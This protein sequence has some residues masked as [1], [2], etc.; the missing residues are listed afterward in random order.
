PCLSCRG[1]G[2]SE[3]ILTARCRRQSSHRRHPR[4]LPGVRGAQAETLADGEDQ[5]VARRKMSGNQ[6]ERKGMVLVKGG[7]CFGL[8]GKDRI[9][10]RKLPWRVRNREKPGTAAFDPLRTKRHGHHYR[11]QLCGGV[12]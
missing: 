6:E 1:I 11:V 8:F 10:I 7:D 12:I 2:F 9:E 5:S 4:Q 3:N